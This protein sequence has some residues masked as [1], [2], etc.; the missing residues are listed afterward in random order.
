MLTLIAYRFTLE[1]LIPQISY[2]TLMDTVLMGATCMVFAALAEAVFVSGLVTKDH[3]DLARKIDRISRIIFPASFI[4]FV[5][6]I[7]ITK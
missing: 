4:T 6:I 3:L 7:A 1:K 5:I 2:L